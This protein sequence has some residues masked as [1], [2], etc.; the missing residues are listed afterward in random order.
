VPL[1]D[2]ERAFVEQHRAAAMITIGADGMPHAVR[3]GAVVVDGKLWSSGTQGRTRTKHLRRDPRATLFFLEQGFGYLTLATRVTLIED[4]DVPDK[5]VRLFQTMQSHMEVPPG[6]LMW[7]GK[8]TSIDDF[9]RIMVE[10]QRLIY[11]FEVL[12]SYGMV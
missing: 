3:V 10:E 9:K 8:P 6:M 2:K 4:P 5:S 12:R 7:N 11:E 1:S